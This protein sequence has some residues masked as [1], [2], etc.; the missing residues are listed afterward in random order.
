MDKKQRNRGDSSQRS[1]LTRRELV[2]TS[3]AAAAA[4]V[5]GAGLSPSAARAAGTPAL[6]PKF[7]PVAGFAPELDLA[8]KVALV[9]GASRGIGRA[10]GEALTALG[11]TVIGT[12]RDVA[13]V[14]SPPA[15]SM[16]NLDIADPKSVE[17]FMGE[18]KLLLGGRK[19]D[20]L[21]NNGG[22]GAWGSIL[23]PSLA[24]KQ[25]HDYYYAQLKLATDTIY[26]GHVGM[27]TQILP[28]MPTSGY[29]RILFTVTAAQYW[30]GGGS[31]APLPG[32]GVPLSV[33]MGYLH[34]Y[35]QAKRALC[36]YAGFLRSRLQFFGSHLKVSTLNPN[37]VNTDIMKGNR[38]IYLEPTDANGHTGDPM[39]D[40]F[41][42][43]MRG[44]LN[45]NP[46][47]GQPGALP[48]AMAGEAYGQLLRQN[49]PP[50]NVIMG[51]AVEPYATMGMNYVAELQILSEN[52]EAAVSWV[53]P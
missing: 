7:Y 23:P 42:D 17:R 10:T 25:K 19:V 21:I 29:A 41:L 20:I 12:S 38:P 22:R 50:P 13:T 40:G 52:P 8:G 35:N 43:G 36:A 44:A 39:H 31:M 45:G 46:A 33:F 24:D 51:S 18:L 48:A 2:K 14:P 53:C 3:V 47:W 32:L 5:V 49:N 16:L 28:L 34:P 27:T 4:G 1:G 9:T 30:T 15:Y 6:A 26:H 37:G 11:A